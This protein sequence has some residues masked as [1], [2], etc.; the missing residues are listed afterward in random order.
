M[1]RVEAALKAMWRARLEEA[2]RKLSSEAFVARFFDAAMMWGASDLFADVPLLPG[3]LF[4]RIAGY[5]IQEGYADARYLQALPGLVRQE[6]FASGELQAVVLPATEAENF[7]HWMFAK[8]KGL[9]VF[10]RC[11]GVAENHWIWQHVREIEDHRPQVEI[12]GERLRST[13]PG[14]WITPEVVLC[15]AYRVGIDGEVAEFTDQGM[16]WTGA[17]G[18]EE[19]ILVPDG[20]VSGAAVEQ[21]SSYLD[22]D[23]R[24]RGELVEADRDALA[25][26]IRRLRSRDPTE[27]LRSLLES[28]QL[29]RYPGLHGHTFSCA[30]GKRVERA[31]GA[32][33]RLTGRGRGHGDVPLS[34]ASLMHAKDVAESFCG[35]SLTLPSAALRTV[36]T[37]AKVSRWSAGIS[38]RR[39]TPGSWAAAAADG[40]AGRAGRI[41][42]H[43]DARRESKLTG[44]EPNPSRVVRQSAQPRAERRRVDTLAPCRLGL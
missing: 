43:L 26:L 30:G 15:A 39:R 17:G 22:E 44:D 41:V 16:A 35:G 20:E 1:Q 28:L 42:P 29:E 34:P 38:P 31:R 19:L 40:S 32:T 33:G 25:Q 27:A 6:Q 11:W 24:W 9:I 23:D 2:K 36:S 18:D 37:A 8:A 13:L 3:R 4:A 7:P 5:P 14:Q 10:T 21:C 12:V